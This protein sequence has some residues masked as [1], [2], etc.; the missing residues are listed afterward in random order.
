[1]S[2][3][4]NAVIMLVAFLKSK[5]LETARKPRESSIV[6]REIKEKEIKG[7]SKKISS[8]PKLCQVIKII[9]LPRNLK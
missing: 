4:E 8:I 1:M 7:M 9:N 3:S 5:A 6:C 2:T